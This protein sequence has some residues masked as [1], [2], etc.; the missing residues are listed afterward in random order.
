MTDSA[1]AIDLGWEP[2][3]EVA[4]PMCGERS[5]KLVLYGRDRLFARPGRYRIV[6]CPTCELRYLSPRATLDA[7]RTHYPSDY[8]IYQKPE[9]LPSWTRSMA[10]KFSTLRWRESLERLEPGAGRVEAPP[11]IGDGGGGR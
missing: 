7:L 4:C 6:S 10:R 11:K 3:E 2:Q 9:D 8:F 1:A 5:N